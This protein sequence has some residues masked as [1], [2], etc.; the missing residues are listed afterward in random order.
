MDVTYEC[1]N[2][3]TWIMYAMN[4]GM[5]YYSFYSTTNKVEIHEE[6]SIVSN[7]LQFLLYNTL[8]S[9][10][11]FRAPLTWVNKMMPQFLTIGPFLY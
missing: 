11:D 2:A 3:Q 8:Q 10:K 1:S 4:W 7:R 6:T 5:D 9:N